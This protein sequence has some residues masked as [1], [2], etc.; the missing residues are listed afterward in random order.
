M[1]KKLKRKKGQRISLKLV[2][3]KK[4]KTKNIKKKRRKHVKIT[5]ISKNFIACLKLINEQRFNN[6]FQE[7][8]KKAWKYFSGENKKL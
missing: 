5:S 7:L 4:W 1:K 6:R 3:L 8:L 2:Q